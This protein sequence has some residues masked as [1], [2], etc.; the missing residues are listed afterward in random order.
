MS[1]D[2]LKAEFWIMA[3]VRRCNDA[4]VS[5]MV[6]HRGDSQGGT[7]VLKINQ[8]EAGCKVLTQARDIDGEAGWLA[9]FSGNLVAEAEADEYIRRAQALDPDLWV[10]EI[11]SRD[12]WHPFEGKEL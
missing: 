9:A 8:F 5:A 3:N 4:G 6:V 12:G 10:V 1:G 11:E 7:L 2:R